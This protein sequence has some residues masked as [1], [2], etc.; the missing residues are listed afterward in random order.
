MKIYIRN[1]SYLAMQE[2]LNSIFSSFG[3]INNIEINK[4]NPEMD[5]TA[6]VDMKNDDDAH[7]ALHALKYKELFGKKII[8][9]TIETI[10]DRRDYEGRRSKGERRLSA[11]RRL[12]VR[13]QPIMGYQDQI[14]LG[15]RE[16]EI[17]RRVSTERRSDADRRE[18][19]RRVLSS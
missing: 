15:K 13:K 8:V 1:L 19:D 18:D 10:D 3:K 4:N 17:E 9:D 7:M 5:P 6:I 2:D 16:I 11:D 12:K 14:N